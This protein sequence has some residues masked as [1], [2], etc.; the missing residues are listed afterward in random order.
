MGSAEVRRLH[1]VTNDGILDRNDFVATA[2]ALQSAL[3]DAAYIHI[4]GHQTTASRKVE[5]IATLD[6]G[7]IIVNDRVDIA[8]VADAAGV[9][10]SKVSLPIAKVRGLL[11]DEEKLVGFSAHTLPEADEAL[12][13]GAKYAFL[14]PVF[15]STSHPGAEPLGLQSFT[16]SP[17]PAIA[18]SLI[19]IGGITPQNAQ[20]VLRAGAAGIAVISAVWNAPDPVRGAMEL[21]KILH[22]ECGIKR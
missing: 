12:R 2:K 8:L 14:G 1:I 19:G 13:Q 20:D 17:I 16:S 7:G 10:L 5:M 4:R 9:H 15:E 11:C 6:R 21:V 3:Q 18:D 22:D